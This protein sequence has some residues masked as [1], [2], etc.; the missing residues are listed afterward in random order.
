MERRDSPLHQASSQTANIGEYCTTILNLLTYEKREKSF[1]GSKLDAFVQESE[2]ETLFL[3][4]CTVAV[5][6]K[7]WQD[8]LKNKR[9]AS[10]ACRRQT[11]ESGFWFSAEER[12]KSRVVCD[13]QQRRAEL[14]RAT[15]Q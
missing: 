15:A 6:R 1:Q 8:A 7:R 9:I 2:I 5:L 11:G 4:R 14:Q 12:E 3:S 10:E 13:R